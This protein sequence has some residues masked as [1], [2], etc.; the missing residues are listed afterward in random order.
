MVIQ[1]RTLESGSTV[2]AADAIVDGG[3]PVTI[4]LV[5]AEGYGPDLRGP[6]VVIATPTATMARKIASQ[7]PSEV[8]AP[9][10]DESAWWEQSGPGEDEAPPSASSVTWTRRGSHICGETSARGEAILRDLIPAVQGAFAPGIAV[11]V[12]R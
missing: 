6:A 12:D 8:G 7:L 11:F 3:D 5:V 10:A 4:A 1:A 2:A 9:T